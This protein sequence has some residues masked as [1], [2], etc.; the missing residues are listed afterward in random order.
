MYMHEYQTSLM[1]LEIVIPGN[2]LPMVYTGYVFFRCPAVCFIPGTRYVFRCPAVC[3]RYGIM[4]YRR[5][6]SFY[7]YGLLDMSLHFF[8]RSLIESWLGWTG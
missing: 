5:V 7:R 1:F 2:G 4:F 8:L 6:P 3:F